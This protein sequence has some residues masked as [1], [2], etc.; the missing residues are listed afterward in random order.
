MICCCVG[1]ARSTGA[2]VIWTH[3][4]LSGIKSDDDHLPVAVNIL[5][6]KQKKCSCGAAV[7]PWKWKISKTKHLNTHI[8]LHTSFQKVCMSPFSTCCLYLPSIWVFFH[9]YQT[10]VL[11]GDEESNFQGDTNFPNHVKTLLQFGPHLLAQVNTSF[12]PFLVWCVFRGV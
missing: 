7:A 2:L 9:M 11:S 8:Q 5:K 10:N 1:A 12:Q 3:L 4:R 6:S